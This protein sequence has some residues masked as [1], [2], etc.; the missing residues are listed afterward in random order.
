[1]FGSTLP[2]WKALKHGTGYLCIRSELRRVKLDALSVEPDTDCEQSWIAADE[3]MPRPPGVL[4]ICITGV[5][6]G[7]EMPQVFEF[8]QSSAL[9][10][11]SMVGE[12]LT[13]TTDAASGA[14][15]S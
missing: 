7:I 5:V 15:R 2:L 4:G 9:S 6:V 14:L 1:L 10:P 13:N 8:R 12:A 11:L 3:D